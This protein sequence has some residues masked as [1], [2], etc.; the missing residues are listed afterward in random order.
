LYVVQVVS[1]RPSRHC[2][3]GV[4]QYQIFFAYAASVT[5]Y[6]AQNFLPVMAQA[7]GLAGASPNHWATWA[8][9][10]GL[11]I[12]LSHMYAQF[13]CW[14]FAPTIQVSDHPV[15]P[16]LGNTVAT[17]AFSAARLA[18]ICQAV[19]MTAVPV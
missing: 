19:P 13:L 12:Q 10:F 5:W 11:V 15:E 18:L 14:D 4:V 17:G 16:S 2:E 3:I 6:P 8:C 9:T 7:F 1:V